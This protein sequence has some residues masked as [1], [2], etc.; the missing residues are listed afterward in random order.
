LAS[1]QLTH[2]ATL[3]SGEMLYRIMK[4]PKDAK[5]VFKGIIFDV[6]QWQQKM[7]DGSSATFERIKRPNTAQIIPTVGDKILIAREKQPDMDWCHSFF[8]GRI[9]AGEEPLEA[10]KREFRE[11]SGM[12][13]NDW[14]LFAEYE[15]ESKIDWTIFIYVARNA[16]KIGEQNFDPGE[17]IEIKEVDFDEFLNIVFSD[18]FFE[19]DFAVDVAKILRQPDGYNVLKKRIFG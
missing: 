7:F 8:G 18:E 2:A 17:K 6:Y 13:T 11:E 14:E 9:E 4:I 10:A 5:K 1:F 12:E 3:A 15:P 19:R 16:A